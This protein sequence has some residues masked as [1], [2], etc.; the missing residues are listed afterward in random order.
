MIMEK[1]RPPGTPKDGKAQLKRVAVAPF[2][3]RMYVAD[4]NR[5]VLTVE[6]PISYSRFKTPRACCHD[7][8]TIGRVG[9]YV[10][11]LEG[12]QAE[13]HRRSQVQEMQG[14]TGAGYHEGNYLLLSN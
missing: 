4:W 13:A 5:L 1:M 8:K 14:S 11:D 2:V 6:T 12:A 10:G 3:E 7:C 9:I